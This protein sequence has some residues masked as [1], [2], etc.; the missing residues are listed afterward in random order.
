MIVPLHV[1]AYHCSSSGLLLPHMLA[2]LCQDIASDHADA[3]GFGFERLKERNQIWALVQFRLEITRPPRY[4]MKL[5]ME[6]W[7]STVGRLRAGREFRM[8]DADGNALLLGSSD[9]MVLDAQS[10]RPQDLS[11]LGMG[12]HLRP[13]R[14]LGDK[15]LRHKPEGNGREL[16]RIRIPVS[17]LDANGHVNNTEYIRFSYDAL[18]AI[19]CTGEM[20]G[21]DMTFH[22]EAFLD[23]ELSLK[24]AW[25][26]GTHCVVGYCGARPVFSALFMFA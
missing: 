16:A 12:L 17:A 13:Q 2:H 18:Y 23:D 20:R 25:A 4:G 3:L 11:A 14:L 6:T 10:R 19:G 9:W 22:S 26:E 5:E 24:Y 15:L 1:K 21:L 7:P 8:A